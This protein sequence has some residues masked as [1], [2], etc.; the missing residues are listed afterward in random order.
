MCEAVSGV[1][2]FFGVG[3]YSYKAVCEYFNSM[4]PIVAV[5]VCVCFWSRRTPF[6]VPG[7]SAR[8]AGTHGDF[9]VLSF[10]R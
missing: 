1:W 7:P 9:M 5:G 3:G 6:L 2:V 8:A 10:S 4:K